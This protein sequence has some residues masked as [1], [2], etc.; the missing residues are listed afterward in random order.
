MAPVA[1]V[2]SV[3]ISIHPPHA[4]RDHY[5]RCVRV[6]SKI[7]IHP[8]HAGRDGKGTARWASEIEISIHPPHAGRDPDS[9]SKS[10]SIIRFQSTRPMRGGTALRLF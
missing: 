10:I 7:S 9:S 3:V 6:I 5:N 2:K 4:G 1:G 8:P